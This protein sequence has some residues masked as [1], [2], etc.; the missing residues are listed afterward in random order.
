MNQYKY[1]THLHTAECSRCA[2]NSAAEFVRF[3]KERGYQGIFI[4][5]HFL[6]GN[7]TVS[8][9]VPWEQ[10]V[11]LFCRGYDTASAA[12][13][14]AGLDVFFGWEYS[15]DWAHLLTYGLGRE[16]LLEHP[17]LLEWPVLDYLDQVHADGGYIVHAH[18]FRDKIQIIH[19]FPGRID[20]LR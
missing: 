11:E 12:G 2:K 19:L 8:P 9:D 16:W 7:T 6:N 4:T 10:R 1:E 13:A 17:D 5:D 14:K 15:Y 18:P 3:Y 20:C